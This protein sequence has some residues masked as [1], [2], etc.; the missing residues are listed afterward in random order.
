MNNGSLKKKYV[1]TS[2]GCD[3]LM[4]FALVYLFYIILHGHLSP[5]GGFQGGVLMVAVFT[6]MY[7]G[8]GRE[9][10]VESLSVHGMHTGEGLAS[11]FYVLVALLGVVEGG[12]FCQNVLFNK[13]NIGNLWSSGTIF[14]MNAAVGVK[15]LTGV[16]V[17]AL[18]MFAVIKETNEES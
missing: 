9:K 11:I 7:L 17:L 12:Y 16:G 14:L 5:G 6:M 2:C 10:T 15:V 13:G 18:Y 1:I 8:Y 3:F 4:P